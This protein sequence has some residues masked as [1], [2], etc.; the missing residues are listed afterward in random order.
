MNEPAN[1]FVAVL[2]LLLLT[3]IVAFVPIALIW[4]INTLGLANAA[5]SVSTWLAALVLWLLLGGISIDN[6]EENITIG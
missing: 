4:A 2:L 3:A 6:S 5:Y 1:R